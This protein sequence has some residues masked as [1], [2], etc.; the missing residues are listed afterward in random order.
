MLAGSTDA[1]W[2]ALQQ[3]QWIITSFEQKEFSL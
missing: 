1:S 3:I 2:G